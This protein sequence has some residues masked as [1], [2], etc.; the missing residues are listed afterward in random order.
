MID[1]NLRWRPGCECWWYSND[2]GSKDGE[3]RPECPVH[4]ET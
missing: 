4:G 2:D 3:Y 1:P